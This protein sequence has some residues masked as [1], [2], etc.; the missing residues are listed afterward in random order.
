MLPC[1]LVLTATVILHHATSR[2]ADS[3]CRLLLYYCSPLLCRL[4]AG[5]WSMV[6]MEHLSG[7]AGWRSMDGEFPDADLDLA[8]KAALQRAHAKSPAYAHEDLRRVNVLFRQ[9]SASLVF[10][11]SS[12]CVA[13]SVRQATYLF[14]HH[15]LLLLPESWLQASC[16]CACLSVCACLSLWGHVYVPLLVYL[17]ICCG[18]SLS[19]HACT[20]ELVKSHLPLHMI[21]AIVRDTDHD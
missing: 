19:R 9:C 7:A 14:L 18:L 21:P 17:C 20:T 3:S 5:G 1:S 16:L 13:A 4:L 15:A 8:L 10:E 2:R 11:S 12:A 6:V